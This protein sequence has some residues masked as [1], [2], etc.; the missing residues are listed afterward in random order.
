MQSQSPAMLVPQ[1]AREFWTYQTFMI[2]LI[3]FPGIKT[4]INKNF[5]NKIFVMIM[6]LRKL[7]KYCATKF[8][9]I[10]YSMYNR[11]S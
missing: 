10:W 2:K 8:G 3:L 1:K 6:G 9:A 5:V 4:S 7:Q 11:A